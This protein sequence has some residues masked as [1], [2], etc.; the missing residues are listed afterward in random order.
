MALQRLALPT[1]TTTSLPPIV[2]NSSSSTSNS[3]LTPF[4]ELSSAVTSATSNSPR[5]PAFVSDPAKTLSKSYITYPEHSFPPRQLTPPPKSRFAPLFESFSKDSISPSFSRRGSLGDDEASPSVASITLPFSA[6]V[7]EQALNPRLSPSYLSVEPQIKSAFLAGSNAGFGHWS[8][9]SE[10]SPVTSETKD[11]VNEKL[12]NV[13]KSL[14]HQMNLK[15]HR[16]QLAETEITRLSNTCNTL[17]D[18]KA[19][20]AENYSQAKRRIEELEQVVYNTGRSS[21]TPRLPSE[22]RGRW[23]NFH[24]KHPSNSDQK[25]S[26]WQEAPKKQAFVAPRVD[27]ECDKSAVEDNSG[28][29]SVAPESIPA[30]TY[31]FVLT[32]IPEMPAEVIMAS[33]DKLFVSPDFDFIHWFENNGLELPESTMKLAGM[34]WEERLRLDELDLE[35]LGVVDA[36]ERSYIM[37]VL[38]VIAEGEVRRLYTYH[39]QVLTLIVSPSP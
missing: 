4:S 39:F 10:S 7:T 1:L 13:V 27:V 31:E 20:L 29:V 11:Q 32:R 26:L 23:A 17:L 36:K 5:T 15:N 18:E 28:E 22:S 33:V 8:S 24:F 37:R 34:S 30:E 12:T 9:R 16:I 14:R 35:H 38:K 6:A 3:P 25:S 21:V 19:K 2:H